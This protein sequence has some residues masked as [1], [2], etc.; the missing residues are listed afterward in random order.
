MAVA[1]RVPAIDG[2]RECWYVACP[3]LAGADNGVVGQRAEERDCALDVAGLRPEAVVCRSYCTRSLTNGVCF[4]ERCVRGVVFCSPQG[5]NR[6]ATSL[7]ALLLSS[8]MLLLMS[9]LSVPFLL[10]SLSLMSLLWLLEVGHANGNI[11][12]TRSDWYGL[13]V[14]SK[15]LRSGWVAG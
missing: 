11:G 8:F 3:R 6:V 7:G 15:R 1:E 2:E 10:L 13:V 14:L 5:A 4:C 12:I 9:P